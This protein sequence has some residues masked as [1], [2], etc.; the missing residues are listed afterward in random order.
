MY[1]GYALTDVSSEFLVSSKP[2]FLG[3]LVENANDAAVFDVYRDY[4][5]VV[6]EGYRL[7][8]WEYSTGSNERVVRL[9]RALFTLGYPTA[10]AIADH[11]GWTS[12][13]PDA[14]RLLDVGCGSAVYGL[15][16]LTRLPHSRLTAQDWPVVLPV[17]QEFAAQLGVAQPMQTLAGD[18]RTAA[19]GGPYDAVF[20]GHILHNY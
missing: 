1:R 8:P 16:A 5:R 19:F 20:L 17:A 13:K 3:A 11:L 7:D 15:V 4:R 10:Q 12:G 6:T 14:L 2:M 18:L 9:T